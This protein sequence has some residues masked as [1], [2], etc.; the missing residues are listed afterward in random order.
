MAASGLTGGNAL[1][2]SVYPF[3]VRDATLIGVDTVLTPIDE[4]RRVWAEMATAFPAA[5]LEDMVRRGRGPRRAAPGPRPHPGRRGEGPD[6]GAA[7][8]RLDRA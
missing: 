1:E 5:L 6:P 8:V 7:R 4:R 3:I 2:T